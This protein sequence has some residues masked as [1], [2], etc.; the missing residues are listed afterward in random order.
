MK[1]IAGLFISLHSG[2]IAAKA[3][4]VTLLTALFSPVAYLTEVAYSWGQNNIIYINFVLGAIVVD[5]IVG[6]T[7][8]IFYK[9][10]FSV[11]KNLGGLMLKTFIVVASAY[12]VEGLDFLSPT[13]GVLKEYISASLRFAVFLYPAGSAAGNMYVVTGG[14]IPPKFIVDKITK[15]RED[16]KFDK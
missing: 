4:A 8:H 11:K 13:T 10:D 15:F 9:R 6:T 2:S 5:H 1:S 14:K 16:G 7:Y 3:Q 12:L